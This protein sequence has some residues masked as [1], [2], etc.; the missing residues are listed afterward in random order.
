MDIDNLIERLMNLTYREAGDSFNYRVIYE[1]NR[2]LVSHEI[3]KWADEQ[4]MEQVSRAERKML[5][6][7]KRMAELEAKVFAYESFIKN[8]NFAPI[9]PKWV[10]YPIT[11]NE[12][13]EL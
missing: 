3:R 13:G 7:C 10:N 4:N 9:L 11:C 12:K 2:D 6:N 5:D 8:S 1:K